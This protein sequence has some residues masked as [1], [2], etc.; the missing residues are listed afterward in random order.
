MR[1]FGI[2]ANEHPLTLSREDPTRNTIQSKPST[3]TVAGAPQPL[4]IPILSSNEDGRGRH[5][6]HAPSLTK[7]L[8]PS[9]SMA[10]RA[11]SVKGCQYRIPT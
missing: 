4:V 9:S 11:A 10:S 2:A 3:E 8:I 7:A 5:D 1:S 6:G